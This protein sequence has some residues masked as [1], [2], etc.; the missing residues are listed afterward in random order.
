[1]S[2]ELFSLIVLLGMF[3]VASI[4]PINLGLMGFVA[5]YLIGI[6]LGGMTVDDIFAVFPGDLF[7][8]LAIA[9][10]NGTVDL[11]VSWGLRL[12]GGNVGL[13]PWIMFVLA[14]VLCSIGALSAAGVAIVAPVA[15]RFAARYRI[16]P[17]LMGVMIVQGVTAGSYSPFSPFGVITNATLASQNLPS[18]PWLLFANS[19][20]FNT[21]VAAGVFVVLGGLRLLGQQG[22]MATVADETGAV[23]APTGGNTGDDQANDKSRITP[24]IAA[25]LAGI[26]VLVVVSFLFGSSDYYDV[27]F[28]AFVIGLVLVLISPRQQGEAFSRMPWSAILLICGVLTYVGVLEQ[29]G[30]ITYMQNVIAGVGSSIVAALGASYVGGVISAFASTAGILGAAIPLAKPI[31]QDWSLSATGVVT[32]IAI[33]FAIVDISPLSTNGAL[34]VANAQG[35]EERAFFRKLLLWAVGVTLLAPL[36]AWFVFVVIGVP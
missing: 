21:A 14:D 9:Q 6:S 19:L 24:L 4:L 28:G 3:V 7:I 10:N 12:V 32:A 18:A 22:V 29:I 26:V 13:I 16:S 31:L 25:T 33:S 30:A 2:A 35:I 23:G 8:L 34:L 27:G 1:M 5:A 15:L 20:L 17:L 11:L 36:V